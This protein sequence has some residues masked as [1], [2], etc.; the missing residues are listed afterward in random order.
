MLDAMQ[1]TDLEV[2]TYGEL[3]KRLTLTNYKIVA[4]T[5]RACGIKHPADRK[6]FAL[7]KL[8]VHGKVLSGH[9]IVTTPGNTMRV[10]T[11]IKYLEKKL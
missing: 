4:T 3:M 5:P 9:P 10:I 11:Y 7:F 8:L 1:K 2:N 6:F